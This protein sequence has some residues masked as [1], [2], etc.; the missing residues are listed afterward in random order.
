[1]HSFFLPELTK[2]SKSGRLSSSGSVAVGNASHVEQL[3][4]HTGSHNAST[5]RGRDE[6]N[7]HTTTLASHL[8]ER[9]RERQNGAKK[10]RERERTSL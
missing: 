1:M 5:T 7:Q 3:L 6:A 2:V 8:R 4:G 9:G 10:E